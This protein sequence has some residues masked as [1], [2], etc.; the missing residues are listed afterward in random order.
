[1]M[2]DKNP[3]PGAGEK[4]DGMSDSEQLKLLLCAREGNEEA[5]AELVHLYTPC[6]APRLLNTA[7]R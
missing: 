3:S 2:K 4:K 7:V 1:M 5:F 6:F